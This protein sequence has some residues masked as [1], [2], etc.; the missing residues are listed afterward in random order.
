LLESRG[1]LVIRQLSLHINPEK[2]YR[3]LASILQDQQVRAVA[4]THSRRACAH[5]EVC[6]SQTSSSLPLLVHV[7]QDPDFACVMIQTLNVILLTSTEL[8]DLRSVPAHPQLV[9]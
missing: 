7:Q 3:A 1:C 8:Y 2:I 9:P 4:C 6:Y 5:G